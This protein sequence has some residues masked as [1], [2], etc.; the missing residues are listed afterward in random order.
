MNGRFQWIIAWISVWVSFCGITGCTDS[1][2]VVSIDM[3]RRET[4][5]TR[6]RTPAV[7][8]A[9]LPQYAHSVSYERHHL[10]IAYLRE[11]TGLNIKQVFPESF[12]EHMRMVSQGKI[13]ISFTNPYVYVITAQRYGQKVFAQ[14]VESSGKAAFRGQIICRKDNE[15]IRTL[16][17][18][19]GKRVIAV[20]LTSAG[21][22]LYP[23]G[24]FFEHG[25]R[26]EDFAEL[27]FSPGPGGKQEKVV[28]AVYSGQFDVGLIREG[29]LNVVAD[30]ID[31]DQIRVLATSEWYPAWV[32]SARPDVAT[33]V[34][35]KIRQALFE[36][37][38]QNPDHQAIL[39]KADF[40]KVIPADD[41][42]MQPV[43]QLM[44][45]LGIDLN[46]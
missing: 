1:E 41:R 39:N 43:W 5:D 25:I 2:Q 17:D 34:I 15:A 3:N 42:D 22:F 28:L 12:N 31:I 11:R 26:Q 13:D 37:D 27:S 46:G 14:I 44:N 24:H 9:Y 20:D 30:K 35:A 10:L 38:E 23:M 33:D 36:L 19:R 6:N 45:T 21:G 32:Y 4:V 18:C 29:T 40:R 8:Y 7:T 16:A